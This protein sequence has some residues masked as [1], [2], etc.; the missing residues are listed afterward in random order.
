VKA[1]AS[2]FSVIITT[3][4]RAEFLAQAVESVRRQT[5]DSWECIIVDDAGPR[6]AQ[7]TNDPRVRVVR[8]ERNGGGGA[9]RN[10]GVAEAR[11]HFLTF[12]DDDD[13]FTPDRLEMAIEALDR[14]PVAICWTR[15]F[16]GPARA[17]RRLEGYVSGTL[18]EGLVP[19][20]GATTVRRDAFLPF[21]EN[22]RSA[23]DVEWWI[24]LVG[25]ASVATVPRI[26][27]L[28]RRHP[29]VRHRNGLAVRTRE[30]VRL[31]ELH[32]RYFLDY[33][34]AAAF[35]WSRI[36][37]LARTVGD[38]RLAR[39]AFARS[40]R[41]RPQA[42]AGWHLVRSLRPSTGSVGLAREAVAA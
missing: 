4:D 27:H 25:A 7:A 15:F 28:M 1:G 38:H 24:R 40:L 20:V 8:R 10:T 36:G 13:L 19:N 26:G 12:L 37:H 32:R 11:G 34:R 23:E 17:G 3:Y 31:M 39:M 21:D 41:I 16:D 33:P 30:N 9:A 18:H 42:A 22:Y 29:G 14:A 2:L 5:V 35:R 6:S